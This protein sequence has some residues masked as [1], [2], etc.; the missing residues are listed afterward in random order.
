MTRQYDV[1][2]SSK[3]PQKDADNWILQRT[4]V[5]SQP[6]KTLTPQSEIPVQRQE[7]GKK[8]ENKTGLP[9]R[10][11]AGIE[12]L[13]GYSMDAVRVHYNSDKPEK[14]NA[15][16]Y[17]QGIDIH[18]APGQEHHLPHESW[19]VVQQL[20]GRVEPTVQ[21][22]GLS[23]NDDAA[24][25]SEADVMGVKAMRM[26]R[27]YRDA[28]N[29]ISSLQQNG[30][31]ALAS[32]LASNQNLDRLTP[33]EQSIQKQYRTTEAEK[34]NEHPFKQTSDTRGNFSQIIQRYTE[35]DIEEKKY[36]VS[37]NKNLAVEKTQRPQAYYSSQEVYEK[38]ADALKSINSP[39]EL[40]MNSEKL[41]LNEQLDLYKVTP[42]NLEGKEYPL[43]QNECIQVAAEILKVED[44]SKW[45][46]NIGNHNIEIEPSQITSLQQIINPF[47]INTPDLQDPSKYKELIEKETIEMEDMKL[48]DNVPGT[49]ETYKEKIQQIMGTD[50][51]NRAARK[52]TWE[53]LKNSTITKSQVTKFFAELENLV[54]DK[55][56]LQ[57]D[58]QKQDELL[59]YSLEQIRRTTANDYNKVITELKQ[60]YAGLYQINQYAQPQEKQAF[61]IFTTAPPILANP[62]NKG[63][64]WNFHFAAVVAR[65]GQDYLTMENSTQYGTKE[66]N[67]L[68]LLNNW[69]FQMYGQA[70]QSFHEERK[71]SVYQGITLTLKP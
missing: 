66:M 1:R 28:T 64:Y 59:E 22:R 50:P 60:E 68:Q 70:E 29:S 48:N 57:L 54:E 15:L 26:T 2:T 56:L 40:N 27:I 11:K 31:E 37:E 42:K 53:F 38:S 7:G 61:A 39:L 62:E 4:A 41:K 6:A 35:Q 16:A 24:L 45:T 43:D 18:M 47:A 3:S 52:L 44:V 25:E 20:Q 58:E 5:R 21:A 19:H 12:N 30:S 10:L 32:P 8:T 36:K 34:Q 67:E 14:I 65:D 23:I 71:T 55:N 49:S 17:T 63:K 9:D 51:E 33:N 13:S 69:S 46:A